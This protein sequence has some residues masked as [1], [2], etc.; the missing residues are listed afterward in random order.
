MSHGRLVAQGS[1][2]ELT[3]GVAA[4]VWVRS[5][6]AEPA[7]GVLAPGTASG[8][9]RR[10]GGR[11]ARVRG[12]SLEDVGTAALDAGVA[13]FELYRPRQSLETVFLELTSGTEAGR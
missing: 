10:G 13:V 3:S 9:A 8:G 1:L 2:D 12:A 4:P 6:D 5:A 11:V 7:A